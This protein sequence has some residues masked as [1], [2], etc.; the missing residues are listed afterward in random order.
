VKPPIDELQRLPMGNMGFLFPSSRIGVWMLGTVTKM[1]YRF[2]IDKMMPD[3]DT[4]GG[5][6]WTLPEYPELKF[7]TENT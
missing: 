2:G 5:T 7:D 3:T 1:I 6:K 4:A